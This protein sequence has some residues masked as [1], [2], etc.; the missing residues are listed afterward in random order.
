[1]NVNELKTNVDLRNF[2]RERYASGASPGAIAREL[3]RAGFITKRKRKWSIGAVR[4][5]I[6]AERYYGPVKK[7]TRMLKIDSNKV[8]V[9]PT[10]KS[11]NELLPLCLLSLAK[12]P[13]V[14]SDSFR[15]IT[16]RF[17][18]GNQWTS[19]S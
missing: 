2:A 14:D 15:Q 10:V 7:P 12:N 11:T 5:A 17:L 9:K 19:K 4:N 6:E 8:S 18:E 13:L 1:M 16:I 3:N